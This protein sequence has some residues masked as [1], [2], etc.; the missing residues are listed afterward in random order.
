MKYSELIKML[1]NSVQP[2][3]D[4][5]R[6]RVL[7]T[8][9]PTM[10][11][12]QKT[13]MFSVLS[14]ICIIAGIYLAVM[15]VPLSK[16]NDIPLHLMGI[17]PISSVT[18]TDASNGI[19]NTSTDF[20]VTT[21]RSMSLNEFRNSFSIE[22]KTEF[23]IKKT[24]GNTFKVCFENDLR[25]DTLYKISSLSNGKKIYSWAFQ[26]SNEFAIS[27]HTPSET[28]SLFDSIKVTFTHSDVENFEQYFSI[29]PSIAGTFEHY[30]KS[31]I[32]IPSSEYQADTMYTVTISGNISGNGTTLGEDYTFSFTPRDQNSYAQVYYKNSLLDTFSLVETPVATII[33]KNQNLSTNAQVYVYSLKDDCDGMLKLIAEYTND[34]SV[35]SLIDNNLSLYVNEISF[36]SNATLKEQA[37]YIKYPQPFQNGYYISKIQLE[38]RTFYHFFQVSDLAVFAL[39][40][41][42]N[43]TFWVNSTT[44]KAAVANSLVEIVDYKSATT[45][46]HGVVLFPASETNSNKLYYKIHNKSNVPLIG[47]IN[48][49]QNYNGNSYTS[50]NIYSNSTIYHIGDTVKVWGFTSETTSNDMLRIYCSWNDSYVDVDMLNNGFFT[51]EIELTNVAKD[52]CTVTLIGADK[53][54]ANTTFFVDDRSSTYTLSVSSDFNAYYR[55]DD[56]NYEINVKLQNGLPANDVTVTTS[57]GTTL[58]TNKYGIAKFTRKAEYSLKGVTNSVPD[59]NTTSFTVKDPNGVILTASHTVAVFDTDIVISGHFVKDNDGITYCDVNT[60][61]LEPFMLNT[62]DITNGNVFSVAN[63]PKSYTEE[64]YDTELT[65]EL[66]KITYKKSKNSTVYDPINDTEIERYKFEEVDEIIYTE[67]YTT[68]DGNVKVPISIDEESDFDKYYLRIY[69]DGRVYGTPYLNCYNYNNEFNHSTEYDFSLETDK[70]IYLN[71]DVVYS[72]LKN[73]QT[74]ETVLDGSVFLS[75]VGSSLANNKT[76]YTPDNISFNIADGLSV[77]GAYFDGQRIKLIEPIKLQTEQESFNIEISHDKEEYFPKDNV[78]LKIDLTDSNDIPMNARLFISVTD[79]IL[80]SQSHMD[81]SYN[82]TPNYIIQTSTYENYIPNDSPAESIVEIEEAQLSLPFKSCLH[83]ETVTTENGRASISFVLPE[84]TGEWNISVM[85]VAND[86]TISVCQKN[87][88]SDKPLHIETIETTNIKNED[89]TIISFG[90]FGEEAAGQ[91]CIYSILL[92]GTEILSDSCSVNSYTSENLGKLSIGTH[93]VSIQASYN[94]ISE[95]VE[96]EIEVEPSYA[97]A[98][99]SIKGFADSFTTKNC[100]FTSDVTIN[101]YDEEYELYF[102]LA[103]KLANFNS[104][105]ALQRIAQKS[106]FKYLI[107]QTDINEIQSLISSSYS[108]LFTDDNYETLEKSVKASIVF[109]DLFDVNVQKKYYEKILS[110]SASISKT[111]YAYVGLAAIGEP[112]SKDLNYILNDINSLSDEDILNI[113]LAYASIG[114]NFTAEK[115]YNEHVRDNLRSINGVTMFFADTS[116]ESEKLTALS[117][118]VASSISA[119]ESKDIVKGMISNPTTED[120]YSLELSFFIQNCIPSLKGTNTVAVTYEDGTIENISFQKIC[121]SSLTVSAEELKSMSFASVKGSVKIIASGYSHLV[122]ITKDYN[123]EAKNVSIDFEDF[124]VGDI[125]EIKVNINVQDESTHQY[126][127]YIEIPYPLELISI[128]A[129][130]IYKISDD[131]SMLELSIMPGTTEMTLECYALYKGNFVLEPIILLNKEKGTHFTSTFEV[132]NIE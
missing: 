110:T 100:S 44:D 66:H 6:N 16:N 86:G 68:V 130:G 40:N 74:S 132:L 71:N 8:K 79:G 72:K 107:N 21:H 105:D 55:T 87:I 51:A 31:W 28:S 129:N 73:N 24:S 54:L 78:N 48:K 26:T 80:A 63:S 57:D 65:V 131:K 36:T 18:A 94:G 76:S 120:D 19:T 34:Y 89:D 99:T 9:K 112:I 67:S 103:E 75:F 50:A 81:Y 39:S 1:S 30:E 96:K 121:G 20:K 125:S 116:Y 61:I 128:E 102:A 126:T 60:N 11:K 83:Y 32:F 35:S 104:N 84:H 111:I 97:K 119:P 27:N 92:D 41:N 77:V 13:T 15:N 56:I 127:A 108:M 98:V 4:A 90:I 7:K 123:A 122:D 109:G 58:K 25:L 59:A 70:S 95:S 2:D 42:D 5:I 88:V 62:D 101:F 69:T 37:L 64:L 14:A 53:E 118:L 93:T 52:E 33:N 3:K 82:S 23:T 49:S 45:D 115:L 43:H 12:S 124:K 85:A 117:S 91:D 46:N 106:A 10:S 47:C 114:D 38:N 113:T 29:Y 17:S 22:P